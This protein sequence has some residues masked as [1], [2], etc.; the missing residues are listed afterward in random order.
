M[1]GHNQSVCFVNKDY[2][3]IYQKNSF[4]LRQLMQMFSWRIN[5]CVDESCKNGDQHCP[6]SH[7]GSKMAFY[8][9]CT[10]NLNYISKDDDDSFC[11]T[12]LLISVMMSDSS[13]CQNTTIYKLAYI[14]GAVGSIVLL[15]AW[16]Y[17]LLYTLY[18]LYTL[19]WFSVA[20]KAVNVRWWQS[21]ESWGP[22]FHLMTS[23]VHRSLLRA[24]GCLVS[25][26]GLPSLQFF[27]SFI[28]FPGH[29]SIF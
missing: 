5:K 24:C 23:P 25:V 10:P 21:S 9:R 11:L 7:C 20:D 28:D 6:M 15:H 2:W 17:T 18:T 26:V 29:I 19:S 27:S 1:A 13:H 3:F 12:S 14:Y 8:S 22:P 4:R 16:L